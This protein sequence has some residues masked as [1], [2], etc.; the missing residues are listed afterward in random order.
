MAKEKRIILDCTKLVRGSRHGS[1]MI[2]RLRYYFGSRFRGS[3]DRT[4]S[5]ESLFAYACAK[6][7][8]AAQVAPATCARASAHYEAW[9]AGAPAP[10]YL[11]SWYRA[12]LR[13]RHHSLAQP[14]LPPLAA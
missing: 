6:Y 2:P 4:M 11:C 14:K 5:D 8:D 3:F 7:V 1:K 9:V 13:D 12:A 10:D